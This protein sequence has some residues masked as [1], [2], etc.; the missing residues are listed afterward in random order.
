MPG[1]GAASDVKFGFW[2]MIGVLAAL[3]V[4]GVIAHIVGK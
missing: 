3:V 4:V 1:S 2:I